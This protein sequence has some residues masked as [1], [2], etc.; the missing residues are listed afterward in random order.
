MIHYD[1]LAESRF[2]LVIVYYRGP[3]VC[4]G[5][6]GGGGGAYLLIRIQHYK[7]NRVSDPR[8]QCTKGVM[9]KPSCRL[10]PSI[11]LQGIQRI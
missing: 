2:V 10:D 6:G 8:S 4:L 9:G 1:S 5:G 7:G 3:P 11:N